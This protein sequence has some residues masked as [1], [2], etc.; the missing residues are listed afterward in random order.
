MA[1]P[2]FSPLRRRINLPQNRAES[3]GR[4]IAR[5]T[6]QE[7][8]GNKDFYLDALPGTGGD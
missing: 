3:R 1:F 2:T 8:I 5:G 7:V 6:Q 4:S